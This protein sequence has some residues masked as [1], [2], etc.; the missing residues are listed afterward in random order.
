VGIDLDAMSLNL[1]QR[2]KT[3]VFMMTTIVA[4]PKIAKKLTKCRN[5]GV[6]NTVSISKE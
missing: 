5:V 2:A 1:T 4:S 6:I 3:T